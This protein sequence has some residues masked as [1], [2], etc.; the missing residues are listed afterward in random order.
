MDHPSLAQVPA[1]DRENIAPPRPPYLQPIHPDAKIPR[2]TKQ[3]TLTTPSLPPGVQLVGSMT[4][5]IDWL[6]YSD[7]DTND[8]GKFPQFAP[9][10][11]M[12]RVK[13]RE[14]DL[15]LLEVQPWAAGLD[16]AGLLKVL[17][18]PHF[19]RGIQVTIVAKQLLALVHDGYLWIGDQQIPIDAA[20]INKITGLSMAGLD[21]GDEFP[22]KHEDTK[23][24]Q[25]M[26]ER[27]GLTKGKRGYHTSAIREQRHRDIKATA[28][29]ISDNTANL[30]QLLEDSIEAWE[31]LQDHPDVAKI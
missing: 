12:H 26:K 3:V 15:T 31:K 17:D 9:A 1:G 28:A 6:K 23:L 2:R 13:Y 5:K 21:L 18:L 27:F 20:L 22:S 4:G 25:T 14:H 8:H 29:K 10:E 19:C 7:H 11:Y 24:A 16:N 30:A